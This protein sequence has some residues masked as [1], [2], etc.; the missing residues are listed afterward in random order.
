YIPLEPIP[1]ITQFSGTELVN[2]DNFYLIVNSIFKVLIIIAALGSVLSL[3]IG[4]VQYMIAGGAV[5]KNRGMER[6]RASLWAMLLVAAT[7][8]AMHITRFTPAAPERAAR[9]SPEQ[10]PAVSKHSPV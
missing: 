1:G 2:P 4:G 3:T 8:T 10:F 9:F 6:A 5:M 7:S